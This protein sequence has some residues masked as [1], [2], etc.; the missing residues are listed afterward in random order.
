MALDDL[1][2][3]VAVALDPGPRSMNLPFITPLAGLEEH[4]GTLADRARAG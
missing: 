1:A 3:R 2:A 4:V